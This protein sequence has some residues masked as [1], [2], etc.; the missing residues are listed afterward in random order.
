MEGDIQ[1]VAK[2]DASTELKRQILAA[3]L[4]DFAKSQSNQHIRSEI[5]KIGHF[6]K[7]YHQDLGTRQDIEFKLACNRCKQ[8]K[9]IQVPYEESAL[10]ADDKIYLSRNAGTSMTKPN[11]PKRLDYVN[12]SQ[13]IMKFFYQEVQKIPE[14]YNFSFQLVLDM[15]EKHGK[16]ESDHGIDCLVD[17]KQSNDVGLQAFDYK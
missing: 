8:D 11:L 14:K 7:C 10:Q 15:L 12:L 13:S 17:T 2:F 4:S 5:L 6:F 9:N 16:L 3:F 1:P